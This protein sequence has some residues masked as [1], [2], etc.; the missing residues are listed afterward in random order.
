MPD[1]VAPAETTKLS[2][3][4]GTLKRAFAK[5][6]PWWVKIA[7]CAALVVGGYLTL[8]FGVMPNLPGRPLTP[9]ETTSL[10]QIFKGSVDYSR[11]RIH[12]SKGMDYIVNPLSSLTDTIIY[13][14]TRSST[15]IVNTEIYEPNYA[16]KKKF[17]DL[18]DEVF[19]HENVHVWQHQNAP[20][21]MAWA[22]MKQGFKRQGGIDGYYTYQLEPGKDLLDYNIEQQAAIITDYYLKV[23]KGE[24]TE[25]CGNKETGAE[26]KALYE[27]TLKNF[28]Q[29][30]SYIKAQAHKLH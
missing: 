20:L 21:A 18:A 9:D 29:N 8:Q 5:K 24:T 17:N 3:L 14:H 12:A 30:P 27:S 2:G 23:S 19:L 1:S 28:K 7:R 4:K 13:G 11:E 6:A 10:S 26:L 22:T 15:I 16:S 25:E